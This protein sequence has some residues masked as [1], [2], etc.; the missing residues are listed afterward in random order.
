V[1]DPVTGDAVG[2]RIVAIDDLGAGVYDTVIWVAGGA[3]RVTQ[4][5]HISVDAAIVGIVDTVDVN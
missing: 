3:A 5:H 2:D 1:L 4:E